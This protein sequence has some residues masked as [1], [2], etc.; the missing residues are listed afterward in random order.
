MER[1]EQI[2]FCE[3][4]L[5]REYSS[6]GIL[7]KLTHEK[8]TFTDTCPD[9]SEDEKEARIIKENQK[10]LELHERGNIPFGSEKSILNGGIIGG[11]LAIVGSLVWFFGALI[12]MD[13]IFFYPPILFILGIV[14]LVKGINQRNE[15]RRKEAASRDVLDIN[16]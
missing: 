15:A 1:S 9:F 7:C 16:E 6:Q 3:K 8:A 14:G 2:K 13:T 12:F 11:S 10:S 5:N 4:C